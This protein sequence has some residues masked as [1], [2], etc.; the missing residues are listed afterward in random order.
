MK[1]FRLRAPSPALLISM[2]ALF[3]ALGGTTYAAATSVPVNSVGTPQLKNLAVTT[4]KIA[5]AAVTAAKINPAGLTV[6]NATNATNAN[7]VGGVSATQLQKAITGTCSVGSAIRAVAANGTVTC[8]TIPPA[9][10]TGYHLLSTTN[11]IA[12]GTGAFTAKFCPA[13]EVPVGGNWSAAITGGLYN[14]QSFVGMLYVFAE[15]VRGDGSYHVGISNLRVS[16]TI[17]VT[18]EVLCA[19]AH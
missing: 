19:T 11:D 13:G 18:V 1:N 6:P 7:T 12:P 3:V 2:I 16:D 8:Q 9:G 5:N 15:G 17:R 4:P 14:G 10:I